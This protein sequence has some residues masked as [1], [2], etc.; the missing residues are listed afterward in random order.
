MKHE[1]FEKNSFLLL[2]GC[3][4]VSAIIWWLFAR[5]T[6]ALEQRLLKLADTVLVLSNKDAHLINGLYPGVGS[7]QVVPISLPAFLKDVRRTKDTIEKGHILFWGAMQ[8]REN[9]EAKSRDR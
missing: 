6:F 9:E 4:I 8:R 2:I 3:G 1:S 7:V 5:Q